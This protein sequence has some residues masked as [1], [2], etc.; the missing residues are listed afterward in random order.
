[1]QKFLALGSRD[2]HVPVSWF[3]NQK[4]PRNGSACL[5]NR[6]L[7]HDPPHFRP[8]T[9]LC[10]LSRSAAV[11]SMPLVSLK[12]LR[13]TPLWRPQSVYLPRQNARLFAPSAHPQPPKF[14]AKPRAQILP[15]MEPPKGQ[16][17]ASIVSQTRHID[18]SSWSR[19]GFRWKDWA[20]EHNS[21][22]E[23]SWF[24]LLEALSSISLL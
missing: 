2:I 10:F 22:W 18:G 6:V 17:D 3:A 5:H 16:A 9:R 20:A 12:S 14:F 15:P 11:T 1:M 13:S 24:L 21:L 4:W 23:P 7:P 19:S 8:S